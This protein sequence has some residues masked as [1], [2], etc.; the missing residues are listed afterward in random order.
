MSYIT[1][2]FNDYMPKIWNTLMTFIANEVG[3][4]ALMGNMYAESGCTPYACQPSRPANICNIYIANVDNHTIDEWSFVHR[5]TSATGGVAN[6][7][8]GFGLCQWTYYSR[9]QNMYNLWLSTGGSIG[10]LSFELSFVNWEFNNTH[11]STHDML[12]N[13]PD[14][15]TASNFV[16]F[17]YE[18]PADKSANVQDTRYNYAL[19]IYNAY[20][21]TTPIEPPSPQPPSVDPPEPEPQPPIIPVD[22]L[23]GKMPIWMY[24]LLRR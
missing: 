9:K 18:G 23:T 4:A 21:G 6:G 11:T 20:A 13:P 17:N 10:D 3:V 15:L 24:P 7:Q 5:G 8:G 22:A 12:Q 14:L 16:L 2:I 1:V 19:Q